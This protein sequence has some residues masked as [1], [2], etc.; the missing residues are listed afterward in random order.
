MKAFTGII[1][2]I[3]YWMNSISEIVLVCM[4]LLTVTDVL[5]RILGASPIIG[6]YELVAVAGAIVIGFAVPRTSWDKGHVFV[7]I[8]TENRSRTV[9]NTFFI[10]TRIAGIIVMAFLAWNLLRKGIHLQKS[11]EVS[12][13]LHVPNFPAAYALAFCFFVESITLITDIF[14]ISED[15]EQK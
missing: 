5:F 8:L 10:I 14:R 2:R 1:K 3:D 13:T 9:K 12:M 6:T 4:M 15:G 7:D 11:G